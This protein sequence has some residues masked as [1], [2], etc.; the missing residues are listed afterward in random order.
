M[1]KKRSSERSETVGRG[2]ADPGS[3]PGFNEFVPT[4]F[5]IPA[6][7]KEAGFR[8]TGSFGLFKYSGA[9]RSS[10]TSNSPMRA[11]APL[12]PGAPAIDLLFLRSSRGWANFPLHVVWGK[13]GKSLRPFS[14]R[15]GPNGNFGPTL[16]DLRPKFLLLMRNAAAAITRGE[17]RLPSPLFILVA[18]P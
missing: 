9:G 14:V 4:R 2:R 11:L 12:R 8:K 15:F 16:A 13:D 6:K 3:L 1:R 5:E 18:S 17:A 7:G 10:A